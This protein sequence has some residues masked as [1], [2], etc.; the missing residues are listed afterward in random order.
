MNKRYIGII[1][2][3]VVLHGCAEQDTAT[4]GT[5]GPNLKAGNASFVGGTVYNTG[6]VQGE[7][8]NYTIFVNTRRNLI[9]DNPDPFSPIATAQQSTITVDSGTV[10]TQL[11]ELKSAYNEAG[12]TM[13]A[14]RESRYTQR[15]TNP[16]FW[17]I[18]PMKPGVVA[19]K[20]ESSR[21]RVESVWEKAEIRTLVI[22]NYTASQIQMGQ[23]RY[24]NDPQMACT[25]CHSVNFGT[26]PS[27][28]LG[29]VV[30]IDDISAAEWISTGSTKDRTAQGV[31]QGHAWSFQSD[32]EKFAT[33][34]YLRSKQTPDE[35]TYAKLLYQ[36]ELAET[37]AELGLPALT[38]Q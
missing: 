30:E 4:N 34:A 24:E 26:A 6:Y 23:Q 17:K 8:F 28:L 12:E 15:L 37:R 9:V 1:L 2:S 21:N 36:E 11:Q 19:I 3:A 27:H 31:A 7:G 5:G 10:A 13:S 25:T 33:V 22:Q 18:T 35:Q 32:Q 20:A 29:R 14:N 38:A 16:S